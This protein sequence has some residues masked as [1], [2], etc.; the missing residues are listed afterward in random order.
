MYTIKMEATVSSHFRFFHPLWGTLI[1]KKKK[2]NLHCRNLQCNK[3]FLGNEQAENEL[4]AVP[5]NTKETSPLI[6][7]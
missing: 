7:L 1:Q 2:K 4:I 3:D 6:P 5:D